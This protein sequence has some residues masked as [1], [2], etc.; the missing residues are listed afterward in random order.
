M[1]I[2]L[3]FVLV[4]ALSSGVNSYKFIYVSEKM[5][6][7]DAQ[8]YCREHHTDLATLNDQVDI[9]IVLKS[10]PSDFGNLMW[11]GLYRTDEYIPWVWVWSDG[12]ES[13]SIPWDTSQPNNVGGHQYC[14]CMSSKGYWSDYWCT[15][16]LPFICYSEKKTQ[17]V[18]LEV[19]SSQNVN[20]PAVK[21]EI[22]AKIE[23]IL[24]DNGVTNTKPSWM[25]FSGENVFH[26]MWYQK[27]NASKAHCSVKP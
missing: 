19:K 23:Q 13:F 15:D 14:V 16:N 10:L 24:K 17:I 8:R 26:N 12:S 20:D 22:M 4:S 2:G 11:I 18:R 9:N 6:W 1:R 5:N 7:T 3:V 21:S 25:T 27:R